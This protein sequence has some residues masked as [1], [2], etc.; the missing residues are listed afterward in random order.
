MDIKQIDHIVLTV[1]D[2]NKTAEFYESVLG[3]D[4]ELFGQ[5][6]VA[7]KFGNQKI[8]LHQ[9]GKEFEPKAENA[10]PG[11]TDLCFITEEKLETAIAHVRN[12]GVEIIEGPVKRT[13]AVGSIISFYF[14]D[15]D[16]NLIEV[17]NYENP[18]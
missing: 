14:R 2:V 6:R 9:A 4:K 12:K 10:V 13:G 16:F 8:N 7:L 5:G 3:M 15:P 1:K 17:A 11:S 18:L